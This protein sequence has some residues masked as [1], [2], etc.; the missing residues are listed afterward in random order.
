MKVGDTLLGGPA[1]ETVAGSDG[2]GCGAKTECCQQMAAGKDQVADLGTWL[3]AS[4]ALFCSWE[5]FALSASFCCVN[6]FKA[7]RPKHTFNTD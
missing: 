6:K 7:F 4:L 2:P 3:F 1:D 5:T